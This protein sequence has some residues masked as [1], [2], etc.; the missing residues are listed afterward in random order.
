MPKS[1]SNREEQRAATRPRRNLVTEGQR[2]IRADNRAEVDARKGQHLQARGDWNPDTRKLE[3][4]AQAT[5]LGQA[6]SEGALNVQGGLRFE[7]AGGRTK[8]RNLFTSKTRG[9]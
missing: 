7:Q 8:K 1:R 5:K 9:Y 4:S 6:Y 3:R 2:A